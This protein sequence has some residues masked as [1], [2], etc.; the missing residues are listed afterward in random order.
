MQRRNIVFDDVNGVVVSLLAAGLPAGIRLAVREFRARF[1]DHAIVT[2]EPDPTS[3]TTI[4]DRLAV[5]EDMR[6]RGK[7]SAAERAAQRHRILDQL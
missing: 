6:E 5:V 1:G 2:G 7:I 3:S 4:E